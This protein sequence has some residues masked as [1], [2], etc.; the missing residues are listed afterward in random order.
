MC[1]LCVHCKLTILV[2][3]AREGATPFAIA[4]TGVRTGRIVREKADCKQS[5][6][7][8]E[9]VHTGAIDKNVLL[10]IN[11]ECYKAVPHRD[12]ILKKNDA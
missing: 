7:N 9:L 4:M 2:T 1:S 11:A 12:N 5:K 10:A 6:L 8:S 3:H